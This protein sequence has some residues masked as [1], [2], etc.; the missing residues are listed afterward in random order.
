[1]FLISA[2]KSNI[3]CILLFISLCSMWMKK[4]SYK[5]E[6]ILQSDSIVT[7]ATLQ[8]RYNSLFLFSMSM[9]LPP[10]AVT[11]FKVFN[12][13]NV[14]VEH[15]VKSTLFSV[16]RYDYGVVCQS[17]QY[18]LGFRWAVFMIFV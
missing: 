5:R 12:C 11:I 4:S 17:H 3:T 6:S 18:I 13:I 1:M 10:I 7:I 14:D 2:L 15:E 16:L 9:I 8:S